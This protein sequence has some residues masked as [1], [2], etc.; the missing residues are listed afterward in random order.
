MKWLILLVLAVLLVPVP[1]VG[2]PLF[3]LIGHFMLKGGERR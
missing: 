1:I 3:L 2:L